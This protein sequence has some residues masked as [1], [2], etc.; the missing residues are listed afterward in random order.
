MI[1]DSNTLIRFPVRWDAVLLKN[2]LCAT[3]MTESVELRYFSDFQQE[4]RKL[5]F[6]RRRSKISP[7]QLNVVKSPN[8]LWKVHSGINIA[9]EIA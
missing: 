9:Q 4:V 5:S 3:E 7:K 6:R 2:E 8:F 1:K